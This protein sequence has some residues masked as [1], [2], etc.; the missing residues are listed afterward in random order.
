MGH[1]PGNQYIHGVDC[2]NCWGLG[3]TFGET[4]TPA[5]VFLTW[6]GFVGDWAGANKAF[7]GIQDPLFP[8][9]WEFEDSVYQGWWTFDAAATVAYIWLKAD[10]LDDVEAFGAL[11]ALVCTVGA[12][13]CVIS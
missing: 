8:C 11:C 3:K 5:E 2:P 13:S 12:V 10:P 4:Y 6:S 1:P 7:V 9:F